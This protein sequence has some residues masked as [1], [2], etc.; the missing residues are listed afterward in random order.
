MQECEALG[1]TAPALTQLAEIAADIE[2]VKGSWVVY[3][4]FLAERDELAHKDWLSMRDQVWYQLSAACLGCQSCCMSAYSSAAACKQF[5]CRAA[6]VLDEFTEWTNSK[7]CV[8]AL[9]NHRCGRLRTSCQSGKEPAAREMAA[10]QTAARWRQTLAKLLLRWYC[11]RRLM[12]TGTV[13]LI[14]TFVPHFLLALLHAHAHAF[15]THM[16]FVG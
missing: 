11:S 12:R 14:H 2:A 13:H 4:E 1:V 6:A 5:P 15:E 7:N 8:A 9:A 3:Q 10:A 16:P